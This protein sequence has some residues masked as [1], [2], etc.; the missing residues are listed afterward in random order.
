LPIA[1]DTDTV[2]KLAEDCEN[3]PGYQLSIDLAAQTITTPS[4]DVI[5]FDVDPFRK[6]SLLEGLDEI[7][8]TLQKRN[9]I[10]DYETARKISA[11]WLFG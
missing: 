1:L 8:L 7:G 5:A 6:E 3:N 9:S 2:N 11:P 10:E 4:G